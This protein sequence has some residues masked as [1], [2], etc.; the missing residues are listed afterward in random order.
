MK[1]SLTPNSTGMRCSDCGRTTYNGGDGQLYHAKPK[2]PYCGR[3]CYAVPIH[4]HK[5]EDWMREELPHN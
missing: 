5:V 4:G 3:G 1:L 2:E